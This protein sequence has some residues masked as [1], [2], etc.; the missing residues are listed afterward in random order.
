MNHHR[1]TLITIMMMTSLAVACGDRLGQQG[2][3]SSDVPG[4]TTTSAEAD[5]TRSVIISQSGARDWQE[6]V[7]KIDSIAISKSDR[8]TALEPLVEMR[9]LEILDVGF[10]EYSEQQLLILSK[11]KSLKVIVIEGNAVTQK[12]VDA[13]ASLPR[14]H[15]IYHGGAFQCPLREGLTCAGVQPGIV[16]R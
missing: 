13:F 7:K 6:V 12:V 15:L 2:A 14:M 4:V 1:L 3:L 10:N 9:R 11:I 8:V 16:P 5:H